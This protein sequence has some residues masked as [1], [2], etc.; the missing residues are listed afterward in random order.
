MLPSRK[1]F[2]GS[3]A[4]VT[5]IAL[6]LLGMVGEQKVRDAIKSASQVQDNVDGL[7]MSTISVEA[8]A[9]R[10]RELEGT[11]RYIA[12]GGTVAMILG[13]LG[14]LLLLTGLYQ[15][16]ILV[17]SREPRSDADSTRPGSP[18]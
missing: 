15:L 1:I 5:S 10:A 16:A 8:M 17:E 4:L 2:I 14:L 9:A 13:I 11:V 6:Q 3:T 7:T 18:L 12:A